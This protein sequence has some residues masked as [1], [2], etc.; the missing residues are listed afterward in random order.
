MPHLFD[1]KWVMKQLQTKKVRPSDASVCQINLPSHP[2]RKVVARFD[3]GRLSSDAGLLCLYALD[4]QHGLTAGFASCLKDARDSRY[5]RHQIRELLTQ[6]SFQI[7]AGYEDCNDATACA[8][9]PSSRPCVIGCRKAIRIWLLNPRCRDWRTRWTRR[10][11]LAWD[12][13]CWRP[14]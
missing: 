11:S 5:V 13:G 4:Q 3:G 6:R 14:T 2:D 9:I 7:V 12:S 10:I 8:R 1:I